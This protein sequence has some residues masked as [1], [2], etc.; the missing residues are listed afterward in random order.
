MTKTF[1]TCSALLCLA[2]VLAFIVPP[3]TAQTIL[4]NTTL[5]SAVTSTSQTTVQ[6]TSTTGLTAGASVIFI[7][8][9]ASS[10]EAMFVN[11]V[12]SSGGYVGVTR[13]YS[14][15]G[16]ARTHASGS[17]VFLGPPF[18]FGADAPSGSCTRSSIQYL[19]SI[20]VGL[21]GVG[22]VISD[23]VGGIWVNGDRINAY[24]PFAPVYQPDPGGTIYTSLNGTGT[25]LAATTEYCTEIDVK[26]SKLLTGLAPLLGT[27]GGTD[28]HIVML[29][30][31]T[32]NL[33]A[34]SAT[35]GTTAGTAS[36]YEQIPFTTKYYLVGPAKY[37]AC[38]QTN[39]TTAT[40]RMLV[41]ST[42]DTYTTKGITGQTFGTIPNPITVPTTFTTA[43]G[44]YWQ[45]Y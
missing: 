11:S 43:V 13:G 35:A 21:G 14:T 41:T 20:A 17:L 18:A 3:A 31:A 1:K 44:P 2:C 16:S 29:Y 4:T 6:L 5:A 7:A 42:Q 38:M 22:T 9:T 33:L 23:C 10:G 24:G 25:V 27:V 34:N 19:P 40:V 15:F 32:G 8:D 12:S 37:Y 36:T 26:G 28:K 30:D 45:L 39:G